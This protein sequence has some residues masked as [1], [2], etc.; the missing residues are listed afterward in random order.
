VRAGEGYVAKN[1]TP[2]APG[3]FACIAAR[4]NGA[5]MDA[6]VVERVFEPF[7]TTKEVGKGTGLGLAMVYGIVTQSGGQIVAEGVPGVGSTFTI[8]LPE[9][10]ETERGPTS[11]AGG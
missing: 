2:L 6:A 3:R 10:A 11:P 7:F 8:Y 5:G 4:D 9:A 1:G